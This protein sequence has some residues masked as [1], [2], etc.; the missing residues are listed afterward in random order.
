ML[1]V[2]SCAYGVFFLLY[3]ISSCFAQQFTAKNNAAINVHCN[4][5]YEYLPSG[6]NPAASQVYP[7]L[8]A[9]HGV[10]ERGNGDGDLARLI[11]PG[12]GIASL[13]YNNPSAFPDHFTVNG[14]D[15]KFIII[16]PQFV[17]NPS[18]PDETDLD[19]VITYM[20]S[21]Y[22]VNA[23]RVYL[24]GLSM[25]GGLVYRFVSA[26]VTNASKIAAAVPVCP[27]IQQPGP[28]YSFKPDSTAS[29]NITAANLPLWVTHNSGDATVPRSITDSIVHFVNAAP[30]P[31]PQAQKT[32]FTV[33]SDPHD[34]WTQ[35]YDPAYVDP[36]LNMNMYQW[37][38]Q[39]QRTIVTLPVKLEQYRAYASA[40]S[41][42]TVAWTTSSEWNNDHFTLERSAN[43]T[44]FTSL[45]VLP[46]QG[47]NNKYSYIDRH[48]IKGNNYYRLSQTDL[49]G[50]KTYFDILK[51]AIDPAQKLVVTMSPNP[52]RDL[53][54]LRIDHEERG[55]ILL[56]LLSMN[57]S[58]I[59][60]W[61]VMKMAYELNETLDLSGLAKGTYLLEVK[62]KTFNTF[63]KLVIN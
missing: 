2:R 55:S 44:D 31:T 41:E 3:S 58:K 21:H 54:Q 4:G 12:K 11:Q 19:A 34:A 14:Q 61:E 38:L 36:V 30:A 29:R 48:P 43:G 60:K 49:G 63:K 7:L 39:Y 51:V 15:Y 28:P 24:T 57:G 33:Y 45:T 18:W 10:G 42:V 25:G 6:Y 50:A 56:S 27:A 47:A 62:A 35:T 20:M 59:K 37:M 23:N 40:P 53:L 1:L 32:I 22:K 46:S 17:D 8:I 13:L 5:Y 16:C 9:I 52:V 26:S